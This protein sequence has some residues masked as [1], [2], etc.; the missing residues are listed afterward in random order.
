MQ[1]KRS[2]ALIWD[3][4]N[5]LI[6][7]DTLCFASH[8]GMK[9][10][11][12]YPLL[13]WKNPK[14][15]HEYVFKLLAEADIAPQTYPYATAQ[16]TLLPPIFCQLLAGN[17]NYTQ[18]R[19][20]FE[21]SYE[22]WKA[23]GRFKSV[24]QER[25][26]SRTFKI[27]FDPERFAQCM[28]PIKSGVDLLHE[29]AQQKDD[30]GNPLHKLFILSNWDAPSFRCLQKIYQSSLFNFFDS[31]NIAISADLGAIK[32][33]SSIYRKFMEKYKLVPQN[34]ILIDDQIENIIGAQNEGM[35]GLLLENENYD[36]LKLHLKKLAIL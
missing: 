14:K 30:H 7:A 22:K 27:L 19:E 4:G 31:H 9:D 35:I 23:Q 1:Q 36:D 26:I 25:L 8:I 17:T 2:M 6:K 29:C 28:K 12:L 34:C 21:H 15:I 11:L 32:P 3:L 24:R 33:Q 20:T 10:F 16:G 18:I 5:T 13:D